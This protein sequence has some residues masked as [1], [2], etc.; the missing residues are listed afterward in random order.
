MFTI[1][2]ITSQHLGIICFI[3]PVYRICSHLHFKA[4][5][6]Q[7]QKPGIDD[8]FRF[9]WIWQ[10]Q[11]P[12]VGLDKLNTHANGTEQPNGVLIG[13]ILSAP[14][15]AR[16]KRPEDHDA[17]QIG[18]TGKQHPHLI[19]ADSYQECCHHRRHCHHHHHLRQTDAPISRSTIV[20]HRIKGG[21]S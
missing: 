13:H 17:P 14:E 6:G 16:V 19:R 11:P 15:R 20:Q 5:K 7:R 3:L 2:Y 1:C 10:L 9:Y 18:K 21:F 12:E 8:N 4:L